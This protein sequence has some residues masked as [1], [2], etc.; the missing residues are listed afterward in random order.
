MRRF[1]EPPEEHARRHL[2][3]HA[4]SVLY[5]SS[6]GKMSVSGRLRRR[7]RNIYGAFRTVG[8]LVC[9]T[10]TSSALRS[11]AVENV[12]RD[13]ATTRVLPVLRCTTS[14]AHA[15]FSHQQE[16]TCHGKPAAASALL[17]SSVQFLSVIGEIVTE[18][19]AP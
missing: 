16:L 8:E 10:R 12:S 17:T 13:N 1:R 2:D 6:S 7:E 18:L 15:N 9:S 5:S 11:A 14:A 4:R 19:V 3:D